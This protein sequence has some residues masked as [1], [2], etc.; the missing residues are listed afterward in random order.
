M[1][2]GL[3]GMVF[4]V[5]SVVGPLLGGAFT[6][7]VSWRWCFYIKY[8]PDFESRVTF[9]DSH[10]PSSLPIGGVAFLIMFFFLRIESEHVNES[11]QRQFIRLDPLGTLVFLPGVV[12]I[13]L[14]LQW[15]GVSYPWNN[16][17]IIALF[18]VGGVLILVFIAIQL[19]RQEDATVPPRI[20]KQRSVAAG[21]VFS[22]C[23]GGGM[24]TML[25]S[26][27]IWFQAVKGVSAVKSGI[28]TIPM[29]LSLVVGAIFSG[30][31]VRRTG[32]YVSWMYVSAICMAVGAGL[33]ATFKTNTDHPKWIGYQVLFGWGIGVGMQ[34]PSMA[35]QNVL[36][37]KDVSTGVSLMFF[38]QSLGGAGFFCIAQNLFDNYLSKHLGEISGIDVESIVQTGATEL[39]NIVPIDK[40]NDVLVVYNQA[41]VRSFIV[42]A[43]VVAFMIVPALAMEWRK[44]RPIDKD[45]A[46]TPGTPGGSGGP[47][48]PE[49]SGHQKEEA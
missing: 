13:L 5:S 12:C 21:V 38:A 4:G 24:I 30:G 44:L 37:R 7:K 29:V 9:T 45:G 8:V 41:L 31:S 17:R 43:A 47:V 3:M 16:G 23:I 42:A 10:S 35:A 20:I 22:M 39:R 48:N 2:M 25:Y 40:L 14:A 18:V 1:Y 33:I 6:D 49:P 19:W 34:Q 27:A 26:L 32:R 36:A 11:L 46:G 15:G 28:D